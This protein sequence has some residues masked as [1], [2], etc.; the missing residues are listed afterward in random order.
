MIDLDN[1]WNAELPTPIAWHSCTTDTE[2]LRQEDLL[3][4]GSARKPRW[5]SDSHVDFWMQL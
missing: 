5:I 2:G 3:Y 4:E 1:H